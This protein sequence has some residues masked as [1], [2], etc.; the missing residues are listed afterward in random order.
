I[1]NG[2]LFTGASGGAGEIGHMQLL[3]EGPL[4]G[5][6]RR[7]CLEALASGRALAR[8]AAE[9]VQRRPEGILSRLL[10]ESGQA[11]N[12]EV[13]GRAASAGDAGAVEALA[14]A[15]RYLGAGFANIVNLFNPEVIVLTGNLR[16][17]GP[18]YLDAA[19][20]VIERETYEQHRRDVRIIETTL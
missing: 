6:G 3:P 18:L 19:Y 15:G 12:A 13:L 5:C 7:G 8:S 11:P 20:A 2:R 10:L 16:K 14:V 1:L 4:C 17:L 9:I